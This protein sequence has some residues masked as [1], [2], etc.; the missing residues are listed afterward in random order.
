M[1]KGIF[2]VVVYNLAGGFWFDESRGK[3]VAVHLEPIRKS[4]V[5]KQREQRAKK[6]LVGTKIGP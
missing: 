6:S 1:M 5:I 4:I 3:R 2:F